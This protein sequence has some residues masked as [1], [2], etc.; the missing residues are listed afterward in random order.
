MDR[1]KK[2]RK[3]PS[4]KESVTQ[5]LQNIVSIPTQKYYNGDYIVK[6]VHNITTKTRKRK[7]TTTTSKYGVEWYFN[8]KTSRDNVMYTF[9]YTN[10]PEFSVNW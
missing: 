8:L 5:I 4:F 2:I 10:I 6:K 3:C 1:Y 7:T 9:F